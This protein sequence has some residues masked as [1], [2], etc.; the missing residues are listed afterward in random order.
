M[1]EPVRAVSPMPDA[2]SLQTFR[3][4]YLWWALFA[5]GLVI[6][7]VVLIAVVDLPATIMDEQH[8]ARIAMS[9]MA[10]DGFAWGP[11]SP[12]SIRPPLYPGALAALWTAVGGVNLQIVRALQIALAGLTA[13]LLHWLGTR[14]FDARVGCLAALAFW[15]YPSLIFFNLLILTETLFTLLLMAFVLLAVARAESAARRCVAL[16]R[17]PRPGRSDAQ[18][19]LAGPAGAVPAARCCWFARRAARFARARSR[20]RRLRARRRA[21]GHPQHQAP[22]R[23]HDRRHDGWDEPADGQLRAHPG[24]SDVGCGGAR[25]EQ[26]WSYALQQEYPGRDFTEG[27]K[28]KWAQRKAVE[29]M[30]SHPGTTVRRSLIKFADFWGLEREFIAGV[31]KGMFSPPLWFTVV[32]ALAHR[33][34]A[35]ARR[36]PRCRGAWLAAPRDWRLHV[37]LLLPV[38]VIAGVHTLVFG[39]SR[40]H[41]PLVPDHG[42]LRLGRGDTWHPERATPCAIRRCGGHS[43]GAV[44]RLGV[45]NPRNR[46]GANPRGD[47]TCWFLSRRAC[48]AQLSRRYRSRCE[49][50]CTADGSGPCCSIST[51][52][53]TASGRCAR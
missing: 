14:A 9:V 11:G 31:Q 36:H 13:L 26:N 12:T 53:C 4:A 23:R 7:L 3:R 52:P 28:E 45:S 32:A 35:A 41:L 49:I 42:H 40:Y 34:R 5:L 17:Y 1:E 30:V 20:L 46:F 2:P 18:R 15:L 19:A 6:R 44:Q 24:R 38:V 33:R 8:Y 50:L 25:G 21:L 47:R 27:E 22:R 43:A 48:P 51:V 16:R 29:Y 37:L 10:G 39:H